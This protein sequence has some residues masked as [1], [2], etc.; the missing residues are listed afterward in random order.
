MSEEQANYQTGDPVN[1]PEHYTTG[2]IETIDFMKAKL[3]PEG[4][5]GYLAGNV[6]KYITRYRHKN[7]LEDLKKARW[8]LNRLVEEVRQR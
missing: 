7:G 5:E 3:S 1:H 8:Y 4:F 2:G 6:M